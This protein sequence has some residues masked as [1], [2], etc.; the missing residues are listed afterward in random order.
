M[1]K[2]QANIGGFSAIYVDLGY[3]IDG[4][5][6]IGNLYMMKPKFKTLKQSLWH[7]LPI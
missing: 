4:T 6:P 5:I 7:S 1:A 3:K 2:L